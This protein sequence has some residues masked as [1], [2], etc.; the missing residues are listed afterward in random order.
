MKELV[1][2]TAACLLIAATSGTA[3]AGM[4]E[5]NLNQ[6]N[7]ERLNKN[8]ICEWR[9]MNENGN[10][11]VGNPFFGSSWK[12]E[13]PVGRYVFTTNCGQEG[14]GSMQVLSTTEKE[15]YIINLFKF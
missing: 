13:L 5:I 12:R 9:V 6:Q 14:G 11:V 2:Y 1:L 7:G 4:I 3:N 10:P 15:H 8:F